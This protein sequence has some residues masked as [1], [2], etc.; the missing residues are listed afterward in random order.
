MPSLPPKLWAELYFDS[1]WNTVTKDIR[2]TSTVT[3][4]RGLSSESSSEA[5]PTASELT[6][7]SRDHKYSPRNVR[8][9]LY[10]KIG[11]NTPMRWGYYTG[12]P[13]VNLPGTNGNEVTTPSNAAYNVTD[14]DLRVDLAIDDWETQ[15]GIA[16]RLTA[17]G[18]NRSWGLYLGGTGQLAF[19]W[20]PTGTVTTITQFST[21][22]IAAYRGQ[23]LTI[24][25]TLDVDNGSGGYELRFYTGRTVDDEE[26]ALLGDPIVGVGTTAVFA[27]TSIVEFGDVLGLVIPGMTGRAY[28]LKL[29]SGIL[30][31]PVLSMTT[32]DASPGMTSWTSNGAVWTT[33]SGAKLTNKHIRMAG[34]IPAWPPTRDLSGNDTVV[35]VSPTGLTR[36]MDA[37]GS[38]PTDS[39]LLRYIKQNDPIEC[40]PLTDGSSARYGA[41]LT[42]GAR[43]NTILTTGTEPVKWSDAQMA[44]WLEDVVAF[45]G[46]T[47]GRITGRVP[48]SGAAASYW[49]VDFLFQ[50]AAPGN[51]GTF[52]IYDRGAGTDADPMVYFQISMDTADDDITVFRVSKG[53]TTSSSSNIMSGVGAGIYD[54]NMHHIRLTMDPGATDTGWAAYI[55]GLLVGGG[56]LAGIVVKAVGKIVHNWSLVSGGG[57][58]GGDQ[59]IAYV[60]YW[61][62]TG[63]AASVFWDAANG[64]PGERAGA[65]IERL[66]TESGYTASVAGESGFQQQMGIQQR[67]KLLEL[68]N[69]ANK[70]NFGYFLDRRDALELIHRS[71]STLWNQTPALTLDFSNGVISAPFRPTDDDKLTENDVSVSRVGGAI[72]ARAVL[73]SGRMSNQEFPDGVGTYDNA[74]EY[75]LYTD[76]QAVNIAY[77]RVHLGTY[78][79][80][81]YTRITLDLAN[82]RVYRMI[83]DILRADVGD[84]IRLANVPEDHGPDD[85][86]VLIQ[87]YSEEAGPDTWRITFN[88]VPAEPWNAFV[89]SSDR[90]SRAD[91]SGSAMNSTA[92]STATS[93]SIKTDAGNT[94]WV[95]SAGFAAEFPFDIRINSGEIVRA[96]AV[97]GTTSPQTF[98]VVRSINGVSAA[99]AADEDVRL[100]YPTYFSL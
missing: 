24:R 19:I 53:E 45:K 98:T 69:E 48:N 82:E 60:S 18:N 83:D 27:A 15:Q 32:A 72:P 43:M 1:T 2:Q 13:W 89:A 91:T 74:Y 76:D 52:E 39:A 46:E 10:N 100:A 59:S 93:L 35:D 99:H 57:I 63:P 6:F 67:K 79:G 81:R 94:V 54:G 37:G 21:V 42:G 86:D 20:S 22:P 9:P 33:V 84:K 23:R 92:T 78:D 31:T 44:D 34:E 75:S 36:R 96:T 58:D 29:M 47:T 55:D 4:S 25:V 87:G 7:D 12:S 85:V 71:H 80:V 64:F 51:V 70:T 73:T 26:W 66:A 30:G 97:T 49:S 38:K 40:W 68:M 95:D 16:A 11:R 28:A 77:M 61:D 17:A 8:S 50:S 14:V 90:Y 5:E 62:I 88:C 56:T 65:R 41:S 3:A